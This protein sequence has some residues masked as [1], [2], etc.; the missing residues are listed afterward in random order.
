[1]K[2]TIY[3][4]AD[5]NIELIANEEQDGNTI[6]VVIE[7]DSAASQELTITAGTAT[8]TEALTSGTKNT[9][10]IPVMLWN[11]GDDTV[12]TLS[13]GG[14]DAGTITIHFPGAIDSDAAINETEN[15]NEVTMQGSASVQEQIIGLQES[16]ERVSA[17]TLAY[18]LPTAVSQSGIADGGSN[19]VET[20]E[21]E[22]GAENV[23]VSFFTCVQFLAET[24]V[25]A[26]NAYEDLMLTITITV[27]GVA[28]AT[29]LHTYRD[30]RQVL[31][32]NHLIENLS[33]GNHTMTVSFAASGGSVSVMQI[34]AAYLLTAKST[35]G[36]SV[37][38]QALCTNGEW[39]PGVL[40][41]GL[42]AEKMTESAY[43]NGV[44]NSVIKKS[45]ASTNHGAM[46]D[47]STLSSWFLTSFVLLYGEY[48][49]ENFY[50]QTD[51]AY[52]K[53]GSTGESLSPT[54]KPVGFT[55]VQFCIPIKRMSGFNI[56]RYEGKTR[57]NNG[58]NAGGTDANNVCIG[59]GAIVNG[60]F[61]NARDDIHTSVDE[62]TTYTVDISSLPY[63]D[64][65]V[66]YGTD[67]A[68]EYKNIS[69]MKA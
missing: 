9:V 60:V 23:K 65:I 49:A 56:L 58:Y 51:G 25:T 10:D 2:N 16:V 55:N 38:T 67:G 68:P 35:G 1:M 7:C 36:G 53:A 27:D 40:A 61:V 64:Y 30:G 28:A 26:A 59:A 11:F 19:T 20:F 6:A 41:D 66:L 15:D 39:S 46:P 24:T 13:K 18:I 47:K 50:M 4:D 45:I 43:I 57:K 69:L 44:E 34:I 14:T 29:I 37:S 21:F 8:T 54:G 17:Q 48:Y 31:T 62:W 52:T 63:I 32:L 42:S 5:L 12:I 33:K 3:A 22:A